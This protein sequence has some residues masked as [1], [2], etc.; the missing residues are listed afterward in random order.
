MKKRVLSLGLAL[1][2]LCGLFAQTA[3][4]LGVQAEKAKAVQWATAHPQ[5]AGLGDVLA[6]YSLG[7]S[8]VSIP[9]ESAAGTVTALASNILLRLVADK[10]VGQLAYDL[11]MKQLPNGSFG[12]G[13]T[14]TVYAVLALNKTLPARFDFEKAQAW[15]AAQQL[16]DGGFAYSGSTG[17]IDMTAMALLVYEGDNTGKAINF[18]QRQM[19]ANGGYISP[20]S[21]KKEENA[22]S[23]ATVITG[24]LACGA[25]VD[26]KMIANMLSFQLADGSFCYQLS[27]KTTDAF[28]T[29]QCLLALGELSAQESVY[30]RIPAAELPLYRDWPSIAVWARSGVTTCFE[31]A[32]M[33]GDNRLNYNPMQNFN[34][35]E[36]AVII[37]KFLPENAPATDPG[38]KD[39]APGAWYYTH[40]CRA[41]AAG[42]LSGSGGLFRPDVAVTREEVAYALTKQLSLAPGPKKPDDIGL[43]NPAYVDAITAV[44]AENLMVGDG[45]TFRPKE[46]ITRQE[47]ATVFAKLYD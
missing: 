12:D 11:A 15:I 24:L 8:G 39:V 38:L 43:A 7:I 42:V 30:T 14:D 32:L 5:T 44:M 26:D 17:D 37:S 31:T 34:K 19:T 21:P 16:A 13:L 28:A 1:V 10:S 6:R 4:A 23:V 2:L 20:W 47:V 18:L 9:A 29:Q 40:V 46:L 33:V 35:A 45:K 36:L 25:V 27:D 3:L 41:I 22:C